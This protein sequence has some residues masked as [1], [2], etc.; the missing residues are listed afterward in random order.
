MNKLLLFISFHFIFASTYKGQNYLTFGQ[1]YNYDIGD[2]IQTRYYKAATSTYTYV[3]K[4]VLNKVF[5]T[6][7]DTIF[8][9]VNL[10]SF[11][12]PY[13]FCSPCPSYTNNITVTDTIT[14]LNDSAT[15]H[16]NE[17]SCTGVQSSIYQDYCNKSVWR[18]SPAPSVSCGSSTIQENTYLI[19]GVGGPFLNYTLHPFG[20]GTTYWEVAF[21]YYSKQSGTCGSRVTGIHEALKEYQ[22]VFVYPN[23]A[24]TEITVNFPGNH[25]IEQLS[26]FDVNGKCALI[27][28]KQ[29]TIDVSELNTGIYFLKVRTDKGEFSRKFIKE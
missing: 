4:T 20:S 23:P 5:S 7:N 28:D 16:H 8:Y 9:T 10:D 21:I 12:A 18:I 22:Q 6:N 2:V 13:M 25:D 29:Q 26:I 17:T 3:T 27:S 1:V 19:E 14:H 11:T 24:A 15:T